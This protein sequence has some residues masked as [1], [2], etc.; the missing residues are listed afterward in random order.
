M[1]CSTLNICQSSGMGFILAVLAVSQALYHPK[2]FYSRSEDM[3]AALL[4]QC[5]ISSKV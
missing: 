2:S 4:E 1:G 5:N 3:H